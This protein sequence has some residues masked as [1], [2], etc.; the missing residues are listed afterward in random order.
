MQLKSLGRAP[1]RTYRSGSCSAVAG[2]ARTR[3]R[4]IVESCNTAEGL[5]AVRLATRRVS[6]RSPWNPLDCW[7]VEH[8]GVFAAAVVGLARRA[9][10]AV[11]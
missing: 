6:I 11:I 7:S 2:I 1:C 3:L 4:R 5:T 8:R 9:R 10:G